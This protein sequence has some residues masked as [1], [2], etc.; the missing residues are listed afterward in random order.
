MGTRLVGD[1]RRTRPDASPLCRLCSA[2]EPVPCD[3]EA[4]RAALAVLLLGMSEP[5]M[6][7]YVA[8]VLALD[9]EDWFVERY[10][11]L[12]GAMKRASAKRVNC[13]R[14]ANLLGWLRRDGVFERLGMYAAADIADVVA[15]WWYRQLVPDYCRRIR[16]ASTRRKKIVEGLR[17]I[18][19][20]YEGCKT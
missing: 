18:R 12:F 1:S 17:L 7:E 3:M 10:A 14:P 16:E 2:L 11:V 8:Q 15:V 19:E 13:R 9:E 6:T 4:E 20:A 5:S